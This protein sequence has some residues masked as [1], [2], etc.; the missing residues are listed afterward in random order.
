MTTRKDE[1]EENVKDLM[2]K[3]LN[4]DLLEA[5]PDYNSVCF[6]DG[7]SLF[8]DGEMESEYDEEEGCFCYIDP[9]EE[10]MT[11]FDDTIEEGMIAYYNKYKASYI[12]YIVYDP[13]FKDVEDVEDVE[14]RKVCY[15]NKHTVK[16]VNIRKFLKEREE[17]NDFKYL[18]IY[19]YLKSDDSN[20]SKDVLIYN[21][22]SWRK[23]EN[24][25]TLM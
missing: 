18:I 11:S 13:V 16:L 25:N 9:C 4:S 10:I 21:K 2:T 7:V 6:E 15:Y 22:D 24:I 14:G 23:I 5:S 1:I 8:S 12:N 20:E 17:Y 3:L 19:E